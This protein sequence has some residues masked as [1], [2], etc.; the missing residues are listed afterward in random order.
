MKNKSAINNIIN[1]FKGNFIA[2]T[3]F[4]VISAIIISGVNSA[5]S[6]TKEEEIKIA[7]E[8]ITRAV[9]SCYAIEG[10]YPESYEYI[11]ENYGV[12]IDENKF[13]VFYDIFSSNIMPEITV[14][15][16]TP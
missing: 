15:E 16:R 7:V 10:F 5:T 14:I 2:L 9:V 1:I 11:K 12:S 4:V 8:S 3:F 6:T 13:A